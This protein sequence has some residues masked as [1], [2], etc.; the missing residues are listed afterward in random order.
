M[1][2]NM[3]VGTAMTTFSLTARSFVFDISAC[4]GSHAPLRSLTPAPLIPFHCTSAGTV[5]Y[6]FEG[7]S[8]SDTVEFVLQ[9]GDGNDYDLS[10]RSEPAAMG[11]QYVYSVVETTIVGTFAFN[12]GSY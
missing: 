2:G 4:N 5:V 11:G 1:C 9:G 3:C 8:S 6:S 10:M 12:V 7:K